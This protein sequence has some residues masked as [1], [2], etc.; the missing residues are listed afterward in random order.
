M[1][2]LLLGILGNLDVSSSTGTTI[3]CFKGHVQDWAW[4]FSEFWIR[5]MVSLTFW[6]QERIIDDRSCLGGPLGGPYLHPLKQKKYLRACAFC[7]KWIF[8][9]AINCSEPHPKPMSLFWILFRCHLPSLDLVP[10]AI[11]LPCS[12]LS[13]GLT[14]F[15]THRVRNRDIS[16]RF[17]GI[18]SFTA[19]RWSPWKNKHPRCMGPSHRATLQRADNIPPWVSLCSLV[20]PRLCSLGDYK[21]R[22]VPPSEPPIIIVFFSRVVPHVM[23]HISS[24]L[25]LEH[26]F[27]YHF[28]LEPEFLPNLVP[29]VSSLQSPPKCLLPLLEWICPDLLGALLTYV[30]IFPRTELVDSGNMPPS[31]K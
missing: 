11:D 31:L 26:S 12:G 16:S 25:Y 15:W 30:V 13:T 24:L 1:A 27:R 9:L 20:I 7:G 14:I 22:G 4:N 18:K 5:P 29:V 8:S 17:L 23:K 21:D 2:G 3:L 19:N 28:L 10:C 6:I